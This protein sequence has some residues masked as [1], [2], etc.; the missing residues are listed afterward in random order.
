M[1]A[2]F[3]GRELN[4]GLDAAILIGFPANITVGIILV[5]ITL[6]LAIGMSYLGLNQMLPFTDLAVT[7]FFAVWA[8]T[9]SRGNV[10]RGVITGTFFIACML[11]IATFLAPATTDLAIAAGFSMPENTAQIS[12]IDSGAHLVPFMLAFGF[13]FGQAQQF[14]TPFMVWISLILVFCIASYIAYFIHIARGHTPGMDDK[15]LY[16]QVEADQEV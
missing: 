10:V 7:S 11:S 14:G 13:I 6:V 4:I 8:T 1:Q 16:M 5:P 2:R 9:W 12:S 15:H 3:P